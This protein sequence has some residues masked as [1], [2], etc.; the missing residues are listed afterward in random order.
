MKKIQNILTAVFLLGLFS[1][2][3]EIAAGDTEISG[4]VEKG[5]RILPVD[6][7]SSELVF[8]IYRGDYIVFDFEGP[9]F[10][11]FKVP[12]LEINAVMP[13]GETEKPYVKM[14]KSGEYSFTLGNRRGVFHILELTEPNYREITARQASDLL[15]NTDPVIIDVRTMGEYENSHISGANL[16]PVQILAQNIDKISHFR[17]EDVFLYCQSGNRSTVAARIL[18]DAGFTN[19]Y[20]LRY[21]IGDWI[22]KGYPVE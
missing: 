3:T 12:A 8:T 10:Y 20:N 18:L 4:Q 5:L 13:K 7:S 16:L 14:K 9:E 2:S 17:N 1:I 6:N 22:R 15:G 21:G 11:D 19:I